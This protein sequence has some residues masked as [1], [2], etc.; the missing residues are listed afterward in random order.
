M[1]LGSYWPETA[2]SVTV[3]AVA[4]RVGVAKT[5]SYRRWHD[6]WE[7]AQDAVNAR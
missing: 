2:T 7:L 3:E 4:A 1:S 5:T 6:K